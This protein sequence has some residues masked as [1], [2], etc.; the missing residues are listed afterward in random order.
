M[1]LLRAETLRIGLELDRAAFVRVRTGRKPQANAHATI[2]WALDPQAPDLKALVAKLA[3]PEFKAPNVHIVLADALLRYFVVERPAGIK[4][5]NELLDVIAG[6][7]EEQFGLSAADWTI[8][9]DLTPGSTFHLACAS[10]KSLIDALKFACTSSRVKLRGVVPYMVS[11]F[12]SHRSALPKR[13]FWFAATT[14]HSVSLCY[15][16]KRD[17]RIARYHA[18]GAPPVDQL[19]VIAA[20]EALRDGLPDG[21]SIQCTGVIGHPAHNGAAPPITLV[22]ASLWPGQSPEWSSIYRLALSGVW[23]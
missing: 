13:D 4:N 14:A 15:R 2:S 21:T 20:R 19:P 17:W 6:R 16:G 9:A 18:L 1:S 3:E 7:F 10:P 8:S 5:H 11:E 12:N 23:R 22:G